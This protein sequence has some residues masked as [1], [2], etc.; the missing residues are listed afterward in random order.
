MTRVSRLFRRFSL[1]V[2]LG[3]MLVATGFAATT[4]RKAFSTSTTLSQEASTLTKL[5]DELHYN[6][7]AVRSAD[8]ASV[9]PDYMGELDGQRL[10]FLGSD[11]ARFAEEYGKNVYYNT[12]FLGNI[13]AAYEIFYVYQTRVEERIA[14]IFENLKK[15]FDF[16]T[17]ETYRADRAKAEWPAD[18]KAS[19]E[20]WQKRLK[21]ELL[22]EILNKKTPDEAKAQVRKRYERMLKNLSEIE[23]KDLAELF[24]TTIAK[25]Y[26]PHST[27]FSA[28]TY[29]DFGIQMKLKLVGIGALLGVED[30][31]CVVK[32]IVPGGPAD[33][34]RQLKPNDK[35]ISVAEKGGEPV[36]ILGMKLRK[37]VDKIRGKKGTDV[38]LIVQPGDATDSSV[39]KE[40]IITRD[41]VKL[42]SARARGAVFDLPIEGK[43]AKIQKLGVITLPAF[44]SEGDDGD[45]DSERS[46]ASKD[47]A[48]LIEQLKQQ[49]IE[50]LVLDLRR[51][52]GGYLSE[53]IDL[54]GLFIQKG[55]VVQ[56]KNFN[57]DIH[58]DSDRDPKIAYTGPLAVLVD[59]FSA[60]ASEIVAGALQNYGRAIVVG[61]SSTHG[62][63]S[64]Q[65]VV[66]MK[67]LAKSLALSPQK[68]GAAKFTIQ[69]YY[70]PSGASTQLKGV[71]PDIVLP[72]IEDY[73]PIGEADLPRALVW[74]QI[75]SSKFEGEPVNPKVLSPLRQASQDRQSKLEEFV[76]LRKN[77]DWFKSRQ[78]QKL[79]SVNL[80]ERQR[81]KASDDAF[82]KEMKAEK[83]RIAKNDYSFKPFYLG[84][85]PPPKI[86]APKKD[87][88]DDDDLDSF[89]EN[90]T[91]V[92][93][94]VHLREAL[95]V[96]TDAIELGRNKEAWASNRAPL[97]AITGG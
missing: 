63:G 77:V 37:I 16:T 70:L 1:P 29:E 41:T 8:Y 12:A 91:Y 13:N 52:G 87:G 28:E 76:Y 43:D 10:F 78:E 79:I 69:K 2:L 48:R 73:L 75:A 22:A 93:A 96:L 62:K 83:E 11:R 24:L 36:E 59:R 57:G 58:V 49:G 50:G 54:A 7:D 4:D 95:R 45:T 39:R 21:F 20:L 15:D 47:V 14:W 18:A 26:D 92:K 84:P 66:E 80:E 33:L 81:Q 27:Y 65:Q 89:E 71:V 38:S 61:D 5:L 35:I 74:D 32:E 85:P 42:N 31:I 97:T 51:N 82:R 60:S 3:A 30:D 88:D 34:G 67:Q 86:R 53:A 19:D 56:V 40:I 25:L 72:S 44:Y 55:P 46:S 9:V 94:D 68:T 17:N 64:V 6:H 90:E 23:G